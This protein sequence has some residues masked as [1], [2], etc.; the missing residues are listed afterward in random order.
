M[1]GVANTVKNANSPVV[2]GEQG[3]CVLVRVQL[4]T[5]SLIRSKILLLNLACE[6]HAMLH[7]VSLYRARR[8]SS[9]SST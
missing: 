3:S 1:G 2:I 6:K 8:R 4:I 7:Y 9:V 5:V